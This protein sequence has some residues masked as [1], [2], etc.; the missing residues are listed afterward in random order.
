[1]R[2]SIALPIA[3]ALA[4]ATMGLSSPAAAT[5]MKEAFK[6]CN[7]S[8]KCQVN[9]DGRGG[10]N[11][12]Y[13]TNEIHCP[14]GGGQCTCVWC[15]TGPGDKGPKVG[16]GVLSASPAGQPAPRSPVIG[17]PTGTNGGGLPPVAKYNR[18]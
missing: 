18:R 2:M 1:M 7:R 6:I 15:K 13:G 11:I 5:T 12:K 17:K 10:A 3:A 16:G 9:G 4:V 8:G 14:G